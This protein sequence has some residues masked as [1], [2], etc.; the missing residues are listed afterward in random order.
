MSLQVHDQ[1]QHWVTVELGRSLI[2]DHSPSQQNTLQ[3]VDHEQ[4]CCYAVTKHK[5]NTVA[6]RFDPEIGPFAASEQSSLGQ[7]GMMFF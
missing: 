4:L 7:P 3:S 5:V 6:V 2:S 1:A